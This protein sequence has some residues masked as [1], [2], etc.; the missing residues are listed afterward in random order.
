MTIFFVCLILI[1]MFLCW[2]II[3]RIGEQQKAENIQF[4]KDHPEWFNKN[5]DFKRNP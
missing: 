5:E 1:S 4:V 2:Q 3:Q